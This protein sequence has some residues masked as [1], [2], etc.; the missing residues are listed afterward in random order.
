M[1]SHDP[2]MPSMAHSLRATIFAVV[3]SSFDSP[4]LLSALN[5]VRVNDAP[6]VTHFYGQLMSLAATLYAL[7][8]LQLSVAYGAMHRQRGGYFDLCWA[9]IC[10]TAHL[11]RVLSLLAAQ[12]VAIQ[13]DAVATAALHPERECVTD[14]EREHLLVDR[15][16]KLRRRTGRK[17]LW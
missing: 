9:P 11:A 3:S 15:F 17:V 13:S 16:L 1:T 8:G 10:D 4:S 2:H 5:V 14:K 12:S 6:S 7:V